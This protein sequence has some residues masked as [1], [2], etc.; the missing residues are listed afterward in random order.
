MGI[1]GEI[2]SEVEKLN[3]TAILTDLEAAKA[4]ISEFE[5]RIVNLESNVLPFLAYAQAAASEIEA[6]FPQATPAIAALLAAIKG[7]SVP[8]VTIPSVTIPSVT[9]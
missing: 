7:L 6:A 8:A 9:K 4:K 2:E 1:L 5:T 3:P